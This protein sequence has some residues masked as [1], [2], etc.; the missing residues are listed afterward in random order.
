MHTYAHDEKYEK[1]KFITLFV[2]SILCMWGINKLF[3]LLQ[4]NLPWWVESPS[5]FSIF[6]IF[7]LLFDNYIWKW[8][9]LRHIKSLYAPN[10]NGKWDTTIYS[11]FSKNEATLA[12]IIIK[13]TA[14][15]I[16]ISLETKNSKSISKIASITYVGTHS[17]YELDYTFENS[18][19]ATSD[20]ILQQHR[21]VVWMQIADDNKSMVGEYFSGRGRQNY[22]KIEMNRQQ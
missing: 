17:D 18:P 11:S 3:I 16:S 20:Q 2:L 8:R 5:V 10:I 15:R 7:L 14:S 6:S 19:K 12:L 13:Q 4:I 22:G 9:F 21:G 1:T